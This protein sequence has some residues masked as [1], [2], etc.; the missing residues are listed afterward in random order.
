MLLH[1]SCFRLIAGWCSVKNLTILD[2]C[3]KVILGFLQAYFVHTFFNVQ[4]AFA[5]IIFVV[6]GAY[7]FA[8]EKFVVIVYFVDF[9]W[10]FFSLF[11]CRLRVVL[12]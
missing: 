5:L 7:L 10:C 2:F 9:A 6:Y 12:L 1:P 11:R 3:S 4:V 8:Y